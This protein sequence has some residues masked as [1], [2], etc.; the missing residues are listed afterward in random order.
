MAERRCP[1]CDVA[2]EPGKLQAFDDTLVTEEEQDG[3]L[4]AAGLH[5]RHDV[6]VRFCPEC[7]LVR[8]YADLEE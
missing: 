4:G 8:L 7:G 3:V 6:A 1:D 2:M 5:R